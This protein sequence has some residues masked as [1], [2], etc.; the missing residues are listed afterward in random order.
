MAACALVATADGEV[1]FAERV[2]VDQILSTLDALK[3]FDPHEGIDIFNEYTDAILANPAEGHEAAFQAM[4]EVAQDPE[5]GALMVRICCAVSEANGDKSLPDQ[6][7][8]T[9]ICSRLG[10]DPGNCGI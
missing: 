5:N 3:V 9:S 4:A 7:E 8:I 2:R 6:I 1:S 10:L